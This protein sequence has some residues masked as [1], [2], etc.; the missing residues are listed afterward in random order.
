MFLK[1]IIIVFLSIV[2]FPIKSQNV[3]AMNKNEEIKSR[4]YKDVLWLTSVSPARNYKNIQVLNQ[5]AEYIHAEFKKLKCEVRYQIFKVDGKEYKNVIANFGPT[6][7]PVKVAGAHYDVAGEQDGADDNASAVAGMLELARYLNEHTQ[8]IKTRIE[9]VAYCLEE[10]PYFAT[11]NMGSAI[12]VNDLVK[13]NIEVKAMICLEMIGYFS[14]KPSSQGFPDE[15]M[16]A[17][18]PNTGNFI[19]VVG[20]DGQEKF[21]ESVKSLM[22]K[23]CSVDVQ[24]IILPAS[25]PLGGLSDHRNYWK[26]KIPSVMINDTSFLR[27]PNYH[28]DSDTIETLD[29]N[30]MTEVVKGVCYTVLHI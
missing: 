10:P 25:N 22:K 21:T 27:N 7:G 4:L 15:R 19:I 26:H 24:S 30:K 9:L 5:V 16:K 29:F 1:P 18:Y 2:A 3:S 20:T 13:N 8:E 14:D 6:T 12:H 17:L 28:E 11:E 23:N